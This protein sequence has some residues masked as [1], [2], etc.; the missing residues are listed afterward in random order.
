MPA[1]TMTTLCCGKLRADGEKAVKPGDAYIV[2]A[3]DLAAEELG[4]DGGLFGDGEIAGSSA[5]DGYLA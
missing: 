4:G 2:E 3:C 1:Q 5:E